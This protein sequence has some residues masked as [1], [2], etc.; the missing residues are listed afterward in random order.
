[1]RIHFHSHGGSQFSSSPP[2]HWLDAMPP[3]RDLW[4][5]TGNA[6]GLV[7]CAV[8]AALLLAHLVRFF[9]RLAGVLSGTADR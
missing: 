9:W 1:M 2:P 4:L 8:L 3:L 7:A 5:L 6:E